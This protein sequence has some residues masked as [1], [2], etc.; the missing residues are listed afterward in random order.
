MKIYL[1]NTSTGSEWEFCGGS[2]IVIAKNED[3]AYELFE[4]EY[5][6][7]MRLK[8]DHLMGIKEIPIDSKQFIKIQESIVE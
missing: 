3:E 2:F 5:G 4:S 6:T 8:G 7:L 1:F